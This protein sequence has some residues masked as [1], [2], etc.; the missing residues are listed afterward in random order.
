MIF[1]MVLKQVT[2]TV[3]KYQIVISN[4]Q[5]VQNGNLGLNQTGWAHLPA[6]RSFVFEDIISLNQI[7]CMYIDLAGPLG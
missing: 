5:A 1:V 6:L 4:I 7:L 2:V 3:G